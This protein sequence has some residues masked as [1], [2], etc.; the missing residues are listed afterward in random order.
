MTTRVA[1]MMNAIHTF[2]AVHVNAQFLFF[3][4]INLCG[5]AGS[6]LWHTGSS[7]L[8]RDRTWAPCLGN[9]ES[10]PLHHQGSP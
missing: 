4:F 8:T 9:A 7:F 10:E 5:S 1:I 6:Q 3:F 2:F